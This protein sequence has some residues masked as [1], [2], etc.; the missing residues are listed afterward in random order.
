MQITTKAAARW[1]PALYPIRDAKIPK[2]LR[3]NKLTCQYIKKWQFVDLSAWPTTWLSKRCK[4]CQKPVTNCVLAILIFYNSP[5]PTKP[6]HRNVPCDAQV[7]FQH[8]NTYL[9]IVNYK[10]AAN[11]LRWKI[12][13]M[14]PCWQWKQAKSRILS[15]NATKIVVFS[16]KIGFAI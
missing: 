7:Q 1:L 13:F 11:L 16:N 3:N 9:F 15:A 2:C 8:E 6:I 14:P 10:K 4:Q 12:S 5:K